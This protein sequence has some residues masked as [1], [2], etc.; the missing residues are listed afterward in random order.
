M[1]ERSKAL[2]VSKTAA[3]CDAS[4]TQEL[5]FSFLVKNFAFRGLDFRWLNCQSDRY[6]VC[7]QLIVFQS[8]IENEHKILLQ[9]KLET[10]AEFWKKLDDEWRRNKNF[11]VK[12]F[13]QISRPWNSTLHRANIEKVLVSTTEFC[14]LWRSWQFW[15]FWTL[16]L[17]TCELSLL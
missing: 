17:L 12:A 1:A 9:S 2:H 13:V 15:F 7:P 5:V 10:F 16:I 3:V 6:L 4:S 14:Q 8:R 11:T